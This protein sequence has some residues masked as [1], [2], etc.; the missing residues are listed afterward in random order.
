MKKF[1]DNSGFTIIELFVVMAIISILSSVV[2]FNWRHAEEGFALQS[3]AY[4]LS[5]EIREIQEMAMGAKEVDCGTEKAHSFGISFS[6]N[7]L[8]WFYPYSCFI[9]AD[10][11]NDGIWFPGVDKIIKEV[12]LEDNVRIC[13]TS[14]SFWTLPLGV[15]FS[16]PDPSVS[17]FS[18]LLKYDW[19]TDAVITLRLD[20]GQEKKIR[21]NKSGMTEIK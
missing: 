5:Q 2:F 12:E 21:V 18:S 6:K 13:D 3:S 1:K 10:C 8:P 15:V 20:S 4:K 11:N 7:T 16:P 17:I 19:G 14:P 9:F